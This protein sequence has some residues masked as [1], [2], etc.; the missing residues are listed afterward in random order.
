MSLRGLARGPV[1]GPCQALKAPLS[2]DV[3]S[4]CFDKKKKKKNGLPII[5]VW[6]G[7]Q[8]QVW[9]STSQVMDSLAREHPG[10][11]LTQR[12][13]PPGPPEMSHH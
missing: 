6:G 13:G 9:V 4:C 11:L 3:S 1:Q 12:G 5:G 10:S 8:A 7:L 2:T